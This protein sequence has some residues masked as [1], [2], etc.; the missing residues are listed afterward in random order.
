LTRV[1]RQGA[2]KVDPDR[3]LQ[4]LVD[5]HDAL[6]DEAGGKALELYHRAS[7]NLRVA[8]DERSPRSITVSGSEEG[9]AV[10]LDR[11]STGGVGFGAA[12]GGDLDSLRWAMGRAA[13]AAPANEAEWPSDF[14]ARV[15]RDD[16]A[17]LPSPRELESWLGRAGARLAASPALAQSHK[18]ARSWVE[19]AATVENL[20]AW[21]GLTAS[22]TRLRAWAMAQIR[23]HDATMRSPRP[24]FVAS[25]G[26]SDLPEK[27]WAALAGERVLGQGA[28]A[29]GAERRLPVLF[30]AEV[31]ANL[32]TALTRTLHGHPE[33]VGTAVGPG[34]AIEDDP[35]A[36]GA[37]LGGSFDD[38]GFASRR[39]VLADGLRAV[40]PLAGAG[41][42][43]RPSFR[44]PPRAMHSHLVLEA[45][46]E[47][48]PPEVL[49]VTEFALHPLPGDRWIL[50]CDG[51]LRRDAESGSVVQGGLIETSP[52]RLVERCVA[53]IGAPAGSHRGVSTPALLFDGMNV[54]F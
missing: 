54:R 41:S 53:R 35:L 51:R 20:V 40:E 37:L 32:V 18:V 30:A 49:F 42:F 8:R 45:G 27:G 5:S 38:V 24:F 39:R 6:H 25:R 34:W 19:V 31:A 26:W 13:A 28:S 23:P 7:I 9:V 16:A 21:E 46:E 36:P 52:T 50:E 3:L 29:S 15:D 33:R 43:R 48:M 11:G 4:R 1:E 2:E 12:S 22:R 10:R 17:R 44:D 47:S 14:E